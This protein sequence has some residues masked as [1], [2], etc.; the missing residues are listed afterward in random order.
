MFNP[1]RSVSSDAG[2]D[3]LRSEIGAV[4]LVKALLLTGLWLLFF[5]G[6]GEAA[7]PD[8]GALFVSGS[9]AG[10]YSSNRISGDAHGR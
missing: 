2:R 10:P 7:K 4:L 1:I 6:G 9:A 3:A 8:V 5:R